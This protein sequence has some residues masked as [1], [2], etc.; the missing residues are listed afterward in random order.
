MSFVAF[1]HSLGFDSLKLSHKYFVPQ[2]F[3]IM[4]FFRVLVII[5][6]REQA[7]VERNWSLVNDIARHCETA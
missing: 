1:I 2:P 7:L 6:I 5:E 3:K 4:S